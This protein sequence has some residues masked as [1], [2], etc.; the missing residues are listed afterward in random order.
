M[1]T[2]TLQPLSELSP[3]ERAAPEAAVEIT[4][5]SEVCVWLKWSHCNSPL[6]YVAV[7]FI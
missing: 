1:T 4:V 2:V 7:D 6:T 5:D 3:A